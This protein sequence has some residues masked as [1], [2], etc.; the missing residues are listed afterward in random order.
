MFVAHEFRSSWHSAGNVSIRVGQSR[1]VRFRRKPARI[2]QVSLDPYRNIQVEASEITRNGFTIIS[3]NL[4]G[5]RTT[6]TVVNWN[7]FGA[8]EGYQSV[9]W[10]QALADSRGYELQKDSNMQVVTVETA[11]ELFTDDF[12][13]TRL[14]LK[15]DTLRWIQKRSIE[16]KMSIWYAEATGQSLPTQFKHEYSNW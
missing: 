9:P 12:L 4:P 13:L 8:A 5:R 2:F 14:K 1:K 15:P 11:F 16:E 6:K 7:A 3:S 10:K